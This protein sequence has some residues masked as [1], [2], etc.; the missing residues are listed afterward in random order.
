MN[1]PCLRPFYYS[2]FFALTF[3][4]LFL[5]YFFRN[6]VMCTGA[7]AIPHTATVYIKNAAAKF[8]FSLNMKKTNLYFYSVFSF[9]WSVLVLGKLVGGGDESESRFPLWVPTS[10]P[11]PAVISGGSPQGWDTGGA[12]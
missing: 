9:F 11:I 10:S 5:D 4:H 2:T 1:K 3:Y 8:S 7:L 12:W 6:V